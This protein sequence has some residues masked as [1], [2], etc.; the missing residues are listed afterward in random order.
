MSLIKSKLKAAMA[1]KAVAPVKASL[2]GSILNRLSQSEDNLSSMNP[3]NDVQS[4]VDTQSDFVTQS[5]ED[6]AI[7]M[8]KAKGGT[9]EVSDIQN[10]AS[11]TASAA[12]SLKKQGE[13]L[14]SQSA[15]G[16]M[17]SVKGEISSLG[18]GIM[19]SIKN[20]ADNLMKDTLKD[21]KKD[22]TE[23]AK[24]AS[25]K[26][27]A[28]GMKKFGEWNKKR[29]ENKQEKAFNKEQ[30]ALV[31]EIKR[32]GTDMDKTNYMYDWIDK[33]AY[34]YYRKEYKA[35]HGM[36]SSVPDMTYFLNEVTRA[37]KISSN[38]YFDAAYAFWSLMGDRSFFRMENYDEKTQTR[39]ILGV[40]YILSGPD[41]ES[42]ASIPAAYL[43]VKTIN[44][45]QVKILN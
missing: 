21:L 23:K 29:K 17:D 14:R 42:L 40:T 31:A 32:C 44:W 45:S 18:G 19:S 36:F 11:N 13:L 16:L 7:L 41:D 37:A 20:E 38:Y 15:A 6:L 4:M 35:A 10:L 5:N 12:S 9:L 1:S 33:K 30:A 3:L 2:S 27:L 25:A 34:E 26:A 39:E 28:S 43:K 24:K 8:A 22:A